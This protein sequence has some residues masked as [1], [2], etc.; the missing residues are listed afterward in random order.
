MPPTAR[1]RPGAAD[2]ASGG[3]R[4]HVEPL[5]RAAV[6]IGVDAL[7]MEVHEEPDHAPS[8]GPNM[9]RL[10]ALGPMLDRLLWLHHA[11]RG[12][13][14]RDPECDPVGVHRDPSV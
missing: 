11:A 14:A 4:R 2:G 5:A 9:V 1:R 12:A 13:D 8:D 3:D 10:D 6:A 7:F